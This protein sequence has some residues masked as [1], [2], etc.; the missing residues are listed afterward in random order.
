MKISR[1]P[2]HREERKSRAGRNFRFFF[3]AL[4]VP[5]GWFFS[6]FAKKLAEADKRYLF[7]LPLL[8][9]A[10]RTELGSFGVG[11]AV[12]T[13]AGG[14]SSR[15]FCAAVGAEFLSVQL[16]AAIRAGLRRRLDHC[17]AALGAEFDAGRRQ[18]AIVGAA[19]QGCTG[20][21]GGV[22]RLA[23]FLRQVAKAKCPGKPF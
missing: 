2:A 16:G 13:D 11:A 10:L 6:I 19:R 21:L 12:R 4:C 17:R 20:A 18:R 5:R 8:R 1:W 7:T 23:G 22:D 15:R 9:A 3:A 14:G